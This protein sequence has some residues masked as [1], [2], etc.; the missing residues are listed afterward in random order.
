MTSIR[1]TAVAGMFYPDDA[2]KIR[3]LF[4]RWWKS[5]A[6]EPSS[7]C[8]ESKH[9][10]GQLPRTLI[11]PHAGYQFSGE[12]ASKGYRLWQKGKAKIQTVVVIGPAHRVYFEGMSALSFQKVDTPL[13]SIIQDIS[14][15]DQLLKQFDEVHL[16]D[17]AQ[18]EEHS[19]E[20]HFPFLKNTLPDVQVLPLLIGHISPG[21]LTRILKYLWQNEG[22]Y[23]VVSTDLSHFLPYEQ[24]QTVDHETAS[25]IETGHV[26]MLSGHR[27]CG[28]QGVQGLL[29][30][31]GD[32]PY[33]L[34]QLALINSGDTAGQRESV[35]GYGAWA[36]Y[37]GLT[38]SDN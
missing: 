37:D 10:E 34:E 4:Q 30:A 8:K 2:D 7:V 20:V 11:L 1:P 27:A 36:L 24:A 21:A 35:V 9:R 28:Y 17:Y 12:I 13:G 3:S 32:Q 16:N 5:H 25:I 38:E 14:L 29:R 33:E 18:A 6:F 15:R 22:V 23:F 31:I 26:E 19:L